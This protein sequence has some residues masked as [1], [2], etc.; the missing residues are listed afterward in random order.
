MTFGTFVKEVRIKNGL[1]LRGFCRIMNFDPGN[2]SR[3][4][5]GIL[6]PPK[7]KKILKEAAKTLTLTENSDDWHT[8]FDLATISFIPTGL[9]DN[10]SVA[11]NLPI[12]FRTMR[13]EKPA[14]K[15]LIDL[16]EKLRRS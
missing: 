13:G 1:T 9:L 5:R 8:L 6:P 4:E 10:Q 15:E 2:W 12:F 14:E 3:I 7:S 16:I 11:D